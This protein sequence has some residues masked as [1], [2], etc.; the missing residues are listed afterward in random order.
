MRTLGEMIDEVRHN[1]NNTDDSRHSDTAIIRFFNTA[2][3][4]VQRL[5]FNSNP[6]TNIFTRDCILTYSSGVKKYSLP[7]DLYARGAIIAVFPVR[8]GNIE[9]EP[10][11]KI[12]EREQTNKAGYYVKDKYIYLSSGAVG[13]A[14][15]QIRVSYVKRL[16][17]FSST[18]DISELPDE[19]EDF[20]TS[21]VERK[22]N[23]VDSSSDVQNS[24][25]FTQ[26]EK[27]ELA[28]LFSDTSNDIKYPVIS[29]ET[30]V[31]Y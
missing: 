30:Y 11:Q 28:E 2:Q 27:E 5:I 8:T 4:Q 10:I 26:E 1:T 12:Y 3:R 9:S 23:A 15:S 7:S 21:F 14:V 19:T 18:S 20:L 17:P 31:T 16:A 24:Q 6:T 13:E 25:F 22:I 29:D